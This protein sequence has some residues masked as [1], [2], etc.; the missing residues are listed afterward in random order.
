MLKRSWSPAVPTRRA[1]IELCF[2]LALL[3]GIGAAVVPC[4]W[5]SIWFDKEF[6][7]WNAPIANRI[8]AGQVLYA[9][10]GHIPIPPLAFLL[11]YWLTWGHATWMSESV[12]NFVFQALTLLVLYTGLS[13]YVARPVPLLA[14]FATV[15]FFFSLQKALLYDSLAQAAV[16]ILA[17]LAMEVACSQRGRSNEAAPQQPSPPSFAR[18]LALSA[19]TG[20]CFLA[21]QSTA[22]GALSG[23]CIVLFFFPRAGSAGQ[24][25]KC[26]ATY[27]VGTVGFLFVASFVLSLTDVFLTGSEPKGGIE[28]MLTHLA[29]Y[30]REM[31]EWSIPTALL[32]LVGFGSG[33]LLSDARIGRHPDVPIEQRPNDDPVDTTIGSLL[34]YGAALA[35]AVLALNMV[36]APWGLQLLETASWSSLFGFLPSALLSAGLLLCEVT[37]LSVLLRGAFAAGV[38]PALAV[39]VCVTFPAAVSHSL[40]VHHFRWTYDNNPLI[41]IALALLLA[42]LVNGI[43]LLLPHRRFSRIV[44]ITGAVFVL[45]LALWTTIQTVGRQLQ[46]VREC[47]QTWPEVAFLT[48]ARLRESADGMRELVHEVRAL[49]PRSTDRVLLLPNDPNVEAW[50]ERPRPTLSSAIIFVDQ[51]WDRF[52]DGDL[53]RLKKDPPEVIVIGPRNRWRFFFMQAWSKPN[54]GADRLIT[55]VLQEILPRRYTLAHSQAITYM[56]NE[57]FMDVFVRNDSDHS[58]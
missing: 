43:N 17:V 14:V 3:G 1:V 24:H 29:A 6:S 53:A 9:D 30:S 7:G 50:F 33:L 39:L 15:P 4:H 45:Q 23:T 44:L 11:I 22:A 12:L 52:V 2:L 55:R 32:A 19:V 58:E 35:A 38:S 27:I 25:L 20:I 18:I 48:G 34:T 10:G 41:A 42:G 40:S 13:R 5:T 57:D 26:V 21:K 47:T 56:D 51:Y 31:W 54:R 49:A 28:L 8:A 46:A 16:A 36:P 37:L